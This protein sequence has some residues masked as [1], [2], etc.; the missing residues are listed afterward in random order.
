MLQLVTSATVLLSLASFTFG[1]VVLDE[2]FDAAELSRDWEWL[3]PVEGPTI[4][5]TERPGWLRMR[6]PQRPTGFNHWLG[7]YEAPLL[8]IPVPNGDWDAE[9]HLQLTEHGPDSTFHVGMAVVFAPERLL[10]LGP[11][12]APQFGAPEPQVWLEPTGRG[13]FRKAGSPADNLWLQFRKRGWQYEAL[14]KRSADAQWQP[15]GDYSTVE[16]PQAIGFLGKT[17]GE[18]QAVVIDVDYVRITSVP[19]HP[20]PQA[21]S[22]AVRVKADR[23]LFRLDPRRYGQFVEL[24]HR[25][26]YGGLW[27][28]MLQNRKF[29]GEV[30]ATGVIERWEPVGAEEGVIFTRDNDVYYVPA[31]SQRIECRGDGQEHGIMQTGLE[32]RAGVGLVGRVVLRARQ[33]EGP[34]TVSVR[35]GDRIVASAEFSPEDEWRTFHFHFRS[36]PASGNLAAMDRLAITTKAKGKLWVGCASL[37]P[38]DNLDG[39]RRD[40]IELCRKMHIPSLRYP[41]GNFAS[42]YHWE[43]GIGPRDRR[44]PRWDRAWNEWEWNDVGTHEYFRL[45]ELLGCEPYITVNAGEGTPSE[46]AAWVEYV[47]GSTRTPQGRRRAANG[48]PK[49]FRCSL[50]SIGNEM[51]GNWQLGHLDATKYAIRT[52]E[53]A[54]AMRAVDP[55]IELIVNGVEGPNPWNV[56]MAEITRHVVNYLSVHHYTSDDPNR[57]PLEDYARI[58]GMPLY[59]ERMLKATYDEVRM[60]IM[61]DEWNVW[62][63]LANQQGYED[64]YQLR[65]GLYAVGVLNALVRLGDKVPGAHLAQTVNVLGAIRTSKTQ[66]V[67]S[68]IALAFQL[69][70]EHSGP[71][72]VPVEV[73]TPQM[74]FPGADTELP[75]VDAIATLP[76]NRDTLH[77]ILVNRHP[78][79]DITCEVTIDGFTPTSG[80][81]TAM[82][83]P[84]FD[85]IN[86]FEKP[87]TV[88]LETQELQTGE[89]HRFTLAR[90][91]AAAVTLK[92]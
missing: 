66:A 3:V 64:F 71:W 8:T 31:Q 1:Q 54:R 78:T 57:S 9:A 6:M 20:I 87:D 30:S 91:S 77:I 86:S 47:N 19:S 43:D 39:F 38:D 15:V 40:V 92:R 45:C 10:T 4:S 75:L 60:P 72:R 67:A 34:V 37:M 44:P 5:L 33:L 82:I 22:A 89:W 24:M 32:L 53:F 36:L 13:G 46:A 17:F 23:E 21:G 18:G 51:Y 11:F 58:V 12:R 27:A 56:R 62:T 68:P 83:G 16:P 84:S 42:G 28:E 90:H 85:S 35:N 48:H 69:H 14:V 80:M 7:V 59:L 79:D 55:S 49:P 63:R 65:D 29:T 61:F 88:R 76:E 81:I 73:D 50:W 2:T 41:G 70:T 25:C 26:F 52:V 74:R